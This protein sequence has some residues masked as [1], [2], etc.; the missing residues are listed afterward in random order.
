MDSLK[1]RAGDINLTFNN[2]LNNWTEDQQ[3]GTPVLPLPEAWV[4]SLVK[5][6]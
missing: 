2:G 6:L 1:I 3:V 4:L 5:E